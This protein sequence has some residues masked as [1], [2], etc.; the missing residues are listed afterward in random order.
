[1][2]YR[3]FE[4]GRQACRG[5]EAAPTIAVVMRKLGVIVIPVLLPVGTE[6]DP[7]IY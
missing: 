6:P 7:T 5:R 1:M 4:I 2:F 3:V